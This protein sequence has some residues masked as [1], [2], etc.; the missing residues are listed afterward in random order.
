MCSTLLISVRV[1]GLCL[2][3]SFCLVGQVITVDQQIKANY[4][5]ETD[6]ALHRIGTEFCVW[7]IRCGLWTQH[8]MT[9]PLELFWFHSLGSSQIHN[10]LLCASAGGVSNL[11]KLGDWLPTGICVGILLPNRVILWGWEQT[12][13]LFR[14][15]DDINP[16]VGSS[17]SGCWL[18]NQM[19]NGG[20]GWCFRWRSCVNVCACCQLI[21]TSL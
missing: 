11:W 17:L 8:F 18:V 1:A 4:C 9:L 7:K 5:G 12:S 16:F 2:S 14:I 21:R 6:H 20:S 10:H 13:F 3:D 19:G 15:A